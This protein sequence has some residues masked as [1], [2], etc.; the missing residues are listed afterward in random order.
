MDRIEPLPCAALLLAAFVLAGLLHS[1]W[2]RSRLSAALDI[3]IDG[4]ATLGGKRLLG[5]NKT[6]RGFVVMV[7]AVGLM[8]GVLGLLRPRLPAG[9]AAGLWPLDPVGYAALGC[10]TGFGFMAAELPNSFCKRR[11][12]IG[13]GEAPLHP[14]GR[15]VCFVCDRLDSVAGAC[16]AL[17]LVV[18]LPAAACAYLVLLG[19][20]I[21]WLF[22]VLLFRL[23]VKARPA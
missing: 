15:A 19:P 18:P 21:H 3:P 7:P 1:A 9:W 20:G 23:G 10:W 12:G 14:V 17:A 2:L 4:F 5:E 6:V 8:F 22:S 13:P 11:L 16:L